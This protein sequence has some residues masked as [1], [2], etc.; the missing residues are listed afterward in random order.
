MLMR[1]AVSMCTRPHMPS[2]T[3]Q[4]AAQVA[5]LSCEG[6]AGTCLLAA[7]RT[8]RLTPPVPAG[9]QCPARDF[10]YTC[11]TDSSV[12]YKT[13]TSA[14]VTE[15]YSVGGQVSV[16]HIQGTAGSA[17]GAGAAPCLIEMTAKLCAA[18]VHTARPTKLPN[19]HAPTHR[20]RS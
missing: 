3:Q 17:S 9:L 1:V 12:D 5:A 10:N 11:R 2:Q 19:V 14:T 6:P 8:W 7:M 13:T 15:K 16:G 20:S 18:L 4:A